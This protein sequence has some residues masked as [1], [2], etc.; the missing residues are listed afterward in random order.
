MGTLREQMTTDVLSVFLNTD[1]V[2]QSVVYR[3]RGG[4]SYT[5]KAVVS[6]DQAYEASENSDTLTGE[7]RVFVSRAASTDTDAGTTIGI[8]NPQIGDVIAVTYTEGQERY[9]TFTGQVSEVTPDSW[10]LH[11]ARDVQASQGRG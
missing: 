4:S 1:E 7:L 2:A 3:P 10:T 11:F 5:V 9:Y 6:G 8:P